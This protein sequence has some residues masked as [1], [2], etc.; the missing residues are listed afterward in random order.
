MI[1]FFL[2]GPN[3]ATTETQETNELVCLCLMSHLHLPTT[4]FSM[5]IMVID[6]DLHG[7]VGV[8][9]MKRFSHKCLHTGSSFTSKGLVQWCKYLLC[10]VWILANLCVSVCR[11]SFFDWSPIDP[12]PEEAQG[13]KKHE[14]GEHCTAADSSYSPRSLLIQIYTIYI[15]SNISCPKKWKILDLKE[16]LF[17]YKHKQVEYIWFCFQYLA[18]RRKYKSII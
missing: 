11:S 10:G 18:L 6:T 4:R 15:N 13:A 5:E 9:C 8:V 14:E 1:Q 2:S 16:K 17:G 7:A 12:R 3:P